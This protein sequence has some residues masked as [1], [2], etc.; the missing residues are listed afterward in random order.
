MLIIKRFKVNLNSP[1]VPKRSAVWIQSFVSFGEFSS[2][3]ISQPNI[4]TV[5]SKQVS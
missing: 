5:V 3:G 1:K 4:E 2:S